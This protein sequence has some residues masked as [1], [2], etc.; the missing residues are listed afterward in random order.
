MSGLGHPAVRWFAYLAAVA[1]L[2]AYAAV[3][4]AGDRL[5]G[6]FA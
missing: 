2:S 3:R 4:R 5:I 1:V 6:R